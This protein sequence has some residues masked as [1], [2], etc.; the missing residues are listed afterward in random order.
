[1][2]IGAALLGL[3]FATAAL[4]QD[5]SAPVA[6]ASREALR[7]WEAVG[8]VEIEGQGYCTGTLI[9]QALVLTAASCII[10]A[11]GTPVEADRISFRA[12]LIEG[13]ALAEA[14]VARTIAPK[15]YRRQDPVP[16]EMIA[17]DVA[18]IELA[19]PM[20]SA[21]VPAFGIA[22]PGTGAD[23]SLV[24]HAG[25]Q[26]EVPFVQKGCTIVLR[27]DGIFGLACGLAKIVPGAP[28]FERSGYRAEIVGIASAHADMDGRAILLAMELADAVTALKEALRRGEAT[29]VATA[30]AV[31]GVK[32]IRPGDDSD[33]GAKF[34]SP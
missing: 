19:D 9:A 30:I 26:I 23:L 11:D 5:G 8:R 14:R 15:D 34:L 25:G 16:P 17:R 18:L 4:A 31:P 27:Q 22:D 6:L 20:P 2:R 7:G 1:M 3:G 33:T 28:V 10:Q 13:V 29:S 24:F 32:R 12:G 21:T